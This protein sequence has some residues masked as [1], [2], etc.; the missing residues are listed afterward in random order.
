MTADVETMR[1]D[2]MSEG[3]SRYITDV[4]PRPDLDG[5]QIRYTFPN[6]YGASVIR[7]RYSYGNEV[8][9]FELGVTVRDQLVYDTPVTDDVLGRLTPE[10]V[11]RALLQIKALPQ[12]GSVAP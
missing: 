3:T 2:L 1:T 7:H 8:G 12:A 9:L 4:I 11:E 10:D 5:G 6:G